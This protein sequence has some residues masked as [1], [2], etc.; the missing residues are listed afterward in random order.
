VVTINRENI[1]YSVKTEITHLKLIKKNN[2][3]YTLVY[4]VYYYI[5]YIIIK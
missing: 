5:L 3:K 1:F 4:L 2:Y